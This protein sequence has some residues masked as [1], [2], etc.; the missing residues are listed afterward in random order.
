MPRLPWPPSGRPGARGLEARLEATLGSLPARSPK[1]CQLRRGGGGSGACCRPAERRGGDAAAQG[2]G[3][4]RRRRPRPRPASRGAGAGRARAALV[5]PL[6]HAPAAAH[7]KHCRDC[8]WCVRTHD[9]H[10]PWIGRCIGENNRTIFLCYLAIQTLELLVYFVEGLHGVSVFEPSA[11]L[12]VGLLCIALFFIMVLTL[13]NYHVF[14][15]LA[16]FTTWEHISWHRI[17]YLKRLAQEDGSP[18]SRSHLGNVVDYCCGARWCPA[19]LR[20]L[21]ALKTDKDLGIVWE[22]AEQ[23][24][25]CCLVAYCIDTC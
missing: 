17:T 24:P 9:H 15:M 21:S 8:G 13:L 22:L 6:Q 4:Q 16:N 23:R 7:E 12:V 25:P 1:P 10:C 20:R 14:L 5:W 3:R 11:L 2:Q 18:F 19:P